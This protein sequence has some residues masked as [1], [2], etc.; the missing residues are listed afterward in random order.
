MTDD[1]FCVDDEGYA[2]LTMAALGQN[3]SSI[4]HDIDRA[5]LAQLS[6]N[7]RACRFLLLLHESE[8]V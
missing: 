8:C 5:T 3:R 2:R 6:S 1:Q 4:T 7:R